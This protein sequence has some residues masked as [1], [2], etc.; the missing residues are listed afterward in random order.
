[1]AL[2]I[3]SALLFMGGVFAAPS[4]SP[5]ADFATQGDR[6]A[7]RTLLQQGADVNA[8][9]GD[10]MTALHWA[11]ELGDAEMAE[12][13]VFAGA[14]VEAETRVGHYTPLH[15]ACRNGSV[16]VAEVLLKAGSNVMARTMPA[17]STPLHLAAASGSAD[18]VR[19]LASR[20]AE[21]NA[22]DHEWEQ[23]P[24]IFA[25]AQNRVAAIQALLEGGAD[26]SIASKVID[27]AADRKLAEAGENR[28]KKVLRSYIMKNEIEGEFIPSASQFQ[29]A[30][31]AG[32]DLYLSGELP[33]IS[34]ADPN[35]RRF[36]PRMVL[37]SK[38]GLTAL[39]HA[40]RQG[41]TEAVMALLEGDADINQVS[42]GDGTSPLLM[43]TINGQND[44][45]L[46]LLGRGADP[47]VAAKVNGVTPLWA[48]VNAKWQPRTRFPQPQ[49]H[50]RQ[51]VTYLDVMDAF[52]KAGA[53]PDARLLSHPWYMVYTGCGNRNC[54]LEDTKGSTAFWRAAYATDVD[55]MRVLVAHGADPH[56]PSLT[57]PPR[58][59]RAGTASEFTDT[60]EIRPVQ[61]FG[62]G[63][64]PAT[65]E[66]TVNPDPSGLPRVKEGDPGVFP[67]HAASGVGYGEGFAGNAHRTAPGAWLGAVKYLIEELGVDVNARDFN[68]YNAL[69][70]AAARGDNEMILYLVEK[71]CDVTAVSRTGQ[72]TADLANGPVQRVSPFPETVALLESLGSKNNHNCVSC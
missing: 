4:S 18:I 49:E 58:R 42:A 6:D 64:W 17:G 67:L 69:H 25:S 22:K 27:L 36:T 15:I 8:A 46:R 14:N 45:A 23:T 19:S 7:V 62:P 30:I 1:M 44:L 59:P 68:G 71:G 66:R 20:G 32:R 52:L 56:I 2:G 63:L 39:L 28:Q 41:H 48:A 70:H 40:A 9:Q 37:K 57:P 24:L 65:D 51:D 13:L 43:A 3:L 26:P 50:D 12:M 55:A 38:G 21:V 61:P 5:V 35:E 33:E 34:E 11:A 47:N 60:A 31:V 72:T 53:D 10:G 16:G 29:A 54:G